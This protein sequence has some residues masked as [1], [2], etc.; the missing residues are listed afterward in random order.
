[1]RRA[2]ALQHPLR[3]LQNEQAKADAA[4]ARSTVAS[5]TSTKRFCIAA[6]N[7]PPDIA[8]ATPTDENISAIPSTKTIAR[9][10][11]RR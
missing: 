1:M 7:S 2:R 5:A 8:T 9:Y 4:S 6:P 3:R 11:T 10:I